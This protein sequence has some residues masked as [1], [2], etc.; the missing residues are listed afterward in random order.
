MNDLIDRQAAIDAINTWDKFGVDERS[1][2]VRWHEGLE[3]YVHLR[4]VVT[5]IVNLPSAQTDLI[6]KIQNGIEVTDADAA[7]SCGMRNG[8]RWCISLIDGKEPLYENCT[9]VQL[10]IIRCKDCKAYDSHDKRCKVWNHGV[11]EYEYC[12]RGWKE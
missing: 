6:A 12:Y 1:R 9:S 11:A 5:A 8:M 3:P 7:Y 10:E 2:M 4:D